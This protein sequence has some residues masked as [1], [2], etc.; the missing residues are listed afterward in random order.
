[1]IELRWYEA[2]PPR[3]A[4][5]A[6]V[7]AMV[8]LLASRPRYGLRRLQPIVVFELWAFPDKLAWLVG[9][10][11]TIARTL[12]GE[13]IAQLPALTL[14]PTRQPARPAPITG[15]EL[16]LTSAVFPLRRESA[17]A[18]T[19][20]LVQ[21]QHQ[22]HQGEAVVVQLVIGP[23][24]RPTPVPVTRTPLDILGFT[25]ARQPDRDELQAWKN[26]LGEPLLGMRGR[27]GAVTIDPRRA[28]EL[29][30]PTV[31]ALALAGSPQAR[32]Y[33]ARQTTRVADQ[34]IDVMGQW[35][36]WS[37][38]VNGGELATLMGWCLGGRDVPGGPGVFAPPPSSLLHLPRLGT[39]VRPLGVS[40]HPAA[41]GA[42]VWLPRT[43]YAT[44]CHLIAPS[45]AGKSTLLAGWITAE[46]AANG[47]LV[48]IEP[49]GDLVADVLARLPENRH[50]NVVVIDPGAAGPVVGFNPLS[51]PR[52]DAERRADNVLGL[53]RELFGTAIGPR[54]ADVL[55]HGLILA[56]RLEDGGL[57]DVIPILTNPQFRRSV[58][59]RVGDP[60]TTAPWLA[61]FDNLSDPERTQAVQPVL[62]KL[63]PWT[64]RPAVRRLLGQAHPKFDLAS[65]FEQRTILLVN[66]NAGALGPETARLV[67]SLL[68]SQLWQA[69]QRQTARPVTHRRPTSVIVDEWQSFTAGLDFA[70]VL[71]RARGANVSFTVAH[72]HFGQLNANLQAAVLANVGARLA[73]RPAEGDGRTLA[74]VFGAPVTP[75][76]LERL[77]AYHAAARVLVDGAPSRTFE[78][79]TP[80]LPDALYDPDQLRRASADRYGMDPAAVDAALIERW[81]G[82]EPPSTPVGVRRTTR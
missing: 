75:D 45:G 22:L 15:R 7:T 58:A 14:V 5:L 40:T 36:T 24:Q 53:L 80:P 34:L 46:A 78:V 27:V 71:A 31:S 42:A 30:R 76:D 6:E 32:V 18:V 12:P 64:A 77:P 50:K 70:D 11:P 61:W 72:Q 8:R 44:H 9:I 62:N 59:A 63:R 81:R 39:V 60:L 47:S 17:E 1:M 82:G 66:L 28:G 74:R 48:V 4:S 23:S 21:V 35:R 26:R 25:E 79:A 73:F 68:L 56:S 65:V 16:R 20:G 67:G 49:K 2:Y 29:L 69:I 19:T 51:G 37:L 41:R 55:L 43:S 33:A 54:S 10:E 57:T 38:V 52:S 13:L 3:N